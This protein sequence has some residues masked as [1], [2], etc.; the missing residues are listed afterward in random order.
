MHIIGKGKAIKPSRV[1]E[2]IKTME[3]IFN[4]HQDPGHGWFEV[5]VLILKTLGIQ[6]QISQ[7]SYRK[8]KVAYLEE[9]CDAGR[10]LR[11]LE[12]NGHRYTVIE[13]HTNN[14]SPI[15]DMES[16]FE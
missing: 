3:F 4:Y 9:D 10:L 5:P 12:A 6:S 11:A 13:K 16:Y 7:Y 1:I 8:G 14:Q 2:G 15:R